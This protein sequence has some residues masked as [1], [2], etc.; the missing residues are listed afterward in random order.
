MNQPCYECGSPWC[1]YMENKK[2]LDEIIDIV[3]NC[4]TYKNANKMYRCYREGIALKWGNLGFA[5]R[6]RCG[7]CWE[8]RV[9][10]RFTDNTNRYTGYTAN[11]E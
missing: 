2:E 10:V 7:W 6:R 3:D 11:V 9:R 5:N 4:S 8:S 1:L